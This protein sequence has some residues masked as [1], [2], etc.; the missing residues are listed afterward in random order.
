MERNDGD[1][2]ATAANNVD[3]LSLNLSGKTVQITVTDGWV[4]LDGQVEWWYQKD[5]A[6]N[7][8][9][10]LS[11]VKGVSAE[12]PDVGA[13]VCRVPARLFRT[14]IAGG[15]DDQASRVSAPAKAPGSSTPRRQ[16]ANHLE[17]ACVTR[18]CQNGRG[19]NAYGTATVRERRRGRATASSSI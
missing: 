8:V 9:R 2:A 6:E 12:G 3:W 7:A 15:A 18:T 11:G 16:G 10:Y 13:L 5:G 14:Q 19:T 1:I 4:T 17:I